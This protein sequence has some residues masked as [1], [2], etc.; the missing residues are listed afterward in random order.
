MSR[1]RI[2][3]APR[4]ASGL[5][6]VDAKDQIPDVRVGAATYRRRMTEVLVSGPRGLLL[7]CR[8]P[9]RRRDRLRGLIGIERLARD[10]AFL[11]TDATSVHT[12]G[13]RF[14][15]LVV[16]LDASMRVVDVRVVRPWKFVPP[17][18][19]ARH[20]LECHERADVQVGDSLRPLLM[21]PESRV[22][23]ASADERANESQDERRTYRQPPDDDREEAARPRGERHGLSSNALRLDDPEELQQPPHR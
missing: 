3:P 4:K 2:L 10:E 8:V 9:E 19:G 20:V 13:M 17:I 5:P 18:R 7:R 21:R 15:I 16:R 12:F 6:T 23:D 22:E 11:V 14:P 1:V